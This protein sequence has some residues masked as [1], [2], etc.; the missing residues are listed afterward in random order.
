MT[1]DETYFATHCG[2]YARQNPTRKLDWYL[3]QATL[4]IE[5]EPIRHLDVG[6]G[7]APFAHTARSPRFVTYGTDVSEFAIEQARRR[8]LPPPS[9]SPPAKPVLGRMRVLIRSQLSTWSSPRRRGESQ[10]TRARF[11]ETFPGIESA[12]SSSTRRRISDR[13][14]ADRFDTGVLGNQ[15]IEESS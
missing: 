13:D 4:W 6:C 1:F 14:V 15:R 10:P 9:P 2:D 8:R 11:S 7:L 3:D 5:T 12:V